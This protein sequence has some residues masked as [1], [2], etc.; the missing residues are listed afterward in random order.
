MTHAADV[1]RPGSATPRRLGVHDC[2][3][4]RQRTD[5]RSDHVGPT[6]NHCGSR[7]PPSCSATITAEIWQ[8]RQNADLYL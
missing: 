8:G 1:V 7:V 4:R 3:E 5:K 6:D 2:A